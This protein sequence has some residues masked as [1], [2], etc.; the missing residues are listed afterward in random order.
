MHLAAIL[1]EAADVLHSLAQLPPAADVGAAP[2]EGVGR[3]QQELER[4]AAEL[5]GATP[6]LVLCGAGM[7][8]MT[9]KWSR[10]LL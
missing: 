5:N 7:S 2:G 1:E 8:R 6:A 9:T 10:R 3:E 4:A